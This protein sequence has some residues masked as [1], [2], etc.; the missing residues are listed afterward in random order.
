M[1]VTCGPVLKPA[2]Q[3]CFAAAVLHAAPAG[4]ERLPLDGGGILEDPC[5]L[6]KGG[7]GAAWHCPLSGSAAGRSGVTAR[8]P[9]QTLRAQLVAKAGS[10]PGLL[11]LLFT[12]R[13]QVIKKKIILLIL[14]YY[15]FILNTIYTWSNNANKKSYTHSRLKF[16]NLISE[17]LIIRKFKK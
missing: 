2:R 5:K 17:K 7:A 9:I 3:S 8:K 10:S 13:D 16:F 4:Q 14:Y 6:Q 11:P 1:V 15:F 12:L